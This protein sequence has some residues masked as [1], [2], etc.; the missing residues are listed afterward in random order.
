[1]PKLPVAGTEVYYERRGSGEPLLLIQ[2]MGGNSAHWGEP[3]LTALE[4]EFELVLFDNRGAGQSGSPSDDFTIADLAGDTLALLD[5]LEIERAHVLGISMGGMVAQELA[6]RAPERVVTLTLGGTTPGGT[7][8][9]ETSSEVVQELTAAVLSGDKE[10]MLR[11]GYEIVVSPEFA[12]DP[13][14]Y[15]AFS[16]IARRYPADISL[17]MSQY[18]AVN[19]HDAYGRLRTLNVPTLVIH[20]TLDR[21]L[22]HI[23]G[24]LIA[25]M[26]PGA[27]L[28]LLDG[29][30]HLFFIEEPERSAQL[31][32]EHAAER[33][34]Q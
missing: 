22:D 18:A 5:A 4:G 11:T 12:A 24:D 25:S 7:Q 16:E 32:R 9:R 10:R 14:N 2:G 30:G 15:A 26:V 31:V 8:A 1:M 23:N 20:G 27:R 13:A 6:L 29:V 21:M 33:T 34:R 28:E 17:L 19:G 3:F